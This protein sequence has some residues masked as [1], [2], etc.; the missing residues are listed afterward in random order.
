MDNKL[1]T[2]LL[3]LGAWRF[4]GSLLVGYGKPFEF[5]QEI[6]KKLADLSIENSES[7]DKMVMST[8][9]GVCGDC[10]YLL[11]PPKKFPCSECKQSI[12]T[13]FQ[14]KFKDEKPYGISSTGS[15]DPT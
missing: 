14:A 2:V 10:V 9:Y 11:T 1:E 4:I 6:K 3:E 5:Y 13:H 15:L 8:A 12:P 7:Y